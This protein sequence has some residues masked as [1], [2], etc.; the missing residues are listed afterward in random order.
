MVALTPITNDSQ[1]ASLPPLPSQLRILYFHAPWAAPCKQMTTVLTHLASTYAEEGIVAF[2][3]IDA[4]ELPD[5]AEAHDV[6]AVPYILLQRNGETLDTVSGGDATRVRAAV[7]KHTNPEA[8]K[9]SVI[10]PQQPVTRPMDPPAPRD[11]HPPT[12]GV[13]AAPVNTGISG[14]AKNLSAYAP[15]AADP[16]TAPAFSSNR[17]TEQMSSDDL[18]KRLSELVKAAPCMLFMKG[19]PSAPQCGFSRQLVSIL[20]EGG[21]RYGFFNILADDEVRQG[22]KKFSDW[23]TF[24]Q[25]YLKGELIGGLDIV[26]EELETDPDYFKDFAVEQ[27]RN[28]GGPAAAEAQSAPAVA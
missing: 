14:T 17:M 7:E 3:S 20:R 2:Y 11:A 4:E 5:L 13:T 28:A 23:P 27:K 21:V 26:K 12:N 9:K 6:S 10:P 18:N 1:L 15:H 25:L 16:P 24:P 19:T 8:D 22:L